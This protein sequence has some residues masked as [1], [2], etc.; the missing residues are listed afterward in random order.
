MAGKSSTG[1]PRSGSLERASNTAASS[2][3]SGRDE[4]VYSPTAAAAAQ[5]R[6]SSPT[7]SSIYRSSSA[8]AGES[9]YRSSTPIGSTYR[10]SSPLADGFRSSTPTSGTRRYDSY[11]T[12]SPIGSYRHREAAYKPSSPY[13]FSSRSRDNSIRDTI[14]RYSS[15]GSAM[16]S[17]YRS[18][19]GSSSMYDSSTGRNR[20]DY[21]TGMDSSAASG[22]AT[23]GTYSSAVND[24]TYSSSPKVDFSYG[25]PGDS[26][27]LDTEKM[28]KRASQY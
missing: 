4:D 10:S 26:T 19:I 2:D 1:S 23:Y 21:L 12:S 20:Y 6:S 24:S 11:T 9:S 3:H 17:S 25:R 7:E 16:N 13:Q 8:S 28:L 14:N 15:G 5:Y 22:Y 18:S 27:K